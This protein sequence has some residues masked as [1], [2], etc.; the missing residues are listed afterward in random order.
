MSSNVL[1]PLT[2]DS[3]IDLPF[4]PS[5]CLRNYKVLLDLL[6]QQRPI[7][8][9]CVFV[10]SALARVLTEWTDKQISNGRNKAL[11][12]MLVHKQLTPYLL[13]SKTENWPVGTKSEVCYCTEENKSI[14]KF[15]APVHAPNF[16]LAIAQIHDPHFLSGIS[17]ICRFIIIRGI[18]FEM[19]NQRLGALVS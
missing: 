9:G 1:Q 7:C 16:S 14:R 13:S 17:V 2:I 4:T 12:T 15:F 19:T 8:Y 3:F 10:I 18:N 6:E 11:S 5:H